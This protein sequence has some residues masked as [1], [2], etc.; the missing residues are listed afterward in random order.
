VPIQICLNNRVRRQRKALL[1]FGDEASFA[2]WG[3]L[4]YPWAPRGHQSLVK[5]SGKKTYKVFSLIGYFSGCFFFKAPTWRLNSL[6]TS[7]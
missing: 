4:S 1:L 6:P 5:I 2:Q 7:Y 3:S